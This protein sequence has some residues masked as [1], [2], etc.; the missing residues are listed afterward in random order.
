MQ[1]PEHFLFVL[2]QELLQVDHK[3]PWV[4]RRSKAY[5]VLESPNYLRELYNLEADSKDRWQEE[6]GLICQNPPLI[7]FARGPWY[8]QYPAWRALE[9]PLIKTQHHVQNVQRSR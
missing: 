4:G 5:T 3:V 9:K 7:P 8:Q 2:G 1:K 6:N